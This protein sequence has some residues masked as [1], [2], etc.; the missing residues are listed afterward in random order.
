MS[1]KTSLDPHRR[2]KSLR[3]G[4]PAHHT[5]TRLSVL[6]AQRSRHSRHPQSKVTRV[7]KVSS[8]PFWLHRE[9]SL[10]LFKFQ[11]GT[12]RQWSCEVY[13][14]TTVRIFPNPLARGFTAGDNRRSHQHGAQLF[15]VETTS[16]T[17]WTCS[18]IS[19]T[20]GCTSLIKSCSARDSFSIR[21]VISCSSSNIAS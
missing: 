7:P 1:L 10:L 16:L 8:D 5:I 19:L 12:K 9:K 17:F 11:K 4:R 20:C 13:I 6:N 14:K 21:F 2:R 18:L 15:W 3:A